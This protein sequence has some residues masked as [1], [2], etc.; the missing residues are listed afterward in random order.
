MHRLA[1]MRRLNDAIPVGLA[2]LDRE[3]RFLSVNAKFASISGLMGPEHLRRRPA[4]VLPEG[5]AVP[6]EGAH[7]E[8]LGTGRP[9][10]DLPLVAEAPGAVRNERHFL[11][12]CHPAFDGDQRLAGV[13][14]VLQDVTER[15]RAERAREL[16]VRELNHRVKN[17][18]A[19]VQS[20]VASTLRQDGQDL[21]RLSATLTA[22]LMALSRAHDLLTAHAWQATELSEVA[23]VAL[24]PWMEGM[25]ARVSIA[26]PEG[27]Q[28]R[29]QQAMMVVLALH[30][31]ATNAIKYGALSGESGQ[32]ALRWRM[33]PAAEGGRT[34]I[35]WVESG[36]PPVVEP[37]RDRRGFG[38]RLLERA[39]AA[40]L[41][42]RA[43]V[44]VAFERA[45]VE[46]EIAFDPVVPH[47]GAEAGLPDGPVLLPRLEERVASVALGGGRELPPPRPPPSFS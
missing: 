2:L 40:D 36:G 22:R 3:Q 5:M 18:L 17:T 33:D 29:P 43:E 34:R 27:I 24:A 39:L 11:T 9:V 15:V 45:G 4:E 31:L 46:A 16:L 1:E 32:V 21:P 35:A 30:E 28:L 26:G 19:T 42:A 47:P 14:L 23:H 44:R 41:G 10:L 7:A 38:M 25:P 37:P 20:I 6:I 13:S 8:V 12:S